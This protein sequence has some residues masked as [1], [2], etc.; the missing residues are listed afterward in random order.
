MAVGG[1]GYKSNLG[2]TK[3]ILRSGEPLEQTTIIH[4]EL[5]SPRLAKDRGEVY[6]EEAMKRIAS[7]DGDRG[8]DRLLADE[9][10]CA[11]MPVSSATQAAA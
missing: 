1:S 3:K 7:A 8:A 4:R 2:H 5:F 10:R 11:L 9:L 6:A